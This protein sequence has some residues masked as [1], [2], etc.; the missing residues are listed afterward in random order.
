VEGVPAQDEGTVMVR[1]LVA[2][3]RRDR[4]FGG[5]KPGGPEPLHDPRLLASD[6]EW[7]TPQRTLY[8]INEMRE[9]WTWGSSPESFD[10]AFEEG[11]WADDGEGRLVCDVRQVYEVK[12]T[13]DFAYER[14]RRVQ[15]TIRDGK[16]SRYEISI[17]G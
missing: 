11:E 15:L 7:F 9:N 2:E 16:I 10:Y 13:G 5:S 3:G 14:K 12:G 1:V 17:V 8:G 6:V 4:V